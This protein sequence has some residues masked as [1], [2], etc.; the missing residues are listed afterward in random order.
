MNVIK[1]YKILIQ[2]IFTFTVLLYLKTK[3]FNFDYNSHQSRLLLLTI[4]TFQKFETK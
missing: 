1:N 2:Y 4:T 3:Y